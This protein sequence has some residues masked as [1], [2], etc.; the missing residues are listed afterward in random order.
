M[1]PSN[2]EAAL[3]KCRKERDVA[4]GH[5]LIGA[6][7][8]TK[9]TAEE[10]H[11]AARFYFFAGEYGRAQKA[12]LSAAPLYSDGIASVASDLSLVC[13]KLGKRE[14][15]AFF[16]MLSR[17]PRQHLRIIRE[18]V[19]DDET[20]S[21]VASA[22]KYLL[23]AADYQVL[24][25][26]DS[27][28]RR[29]FDQ[30][31]A[32]AAQAMAERS[33]PEAAMLLARAKLGLRKFG[34]AGAVV[35]AVLPRVKGDYLAHE[36]LSIASEHAG[37]HRS[38]LTH[39]EKAMSLN[40]ALRSAPG[41][42]AKLRLS[43]GDVK[44]AWEDIQVAKKR[45]PKLASIWALAGRIESCLGNHEA[46][47]ENFREEERLS[48]SYLSA[49][50]LARAHQRCGNEIEYLRYYNEGM[51]RSYSLTRKTW[52]ASRN[53]FVLLAPGGG[54]IL[55][56]YALPG[57]AL[58]V[59]DASATYYTLCAEHIAGR[60]LDLVEAE[61]FESVVF[62]GSS[63][64]A[65]ASLIIGAIVAKSDRCT[66]AVKALSFS[67]QVRLYPLNENL[68]IPSYRPLLRRA[69]ESEHIREALEKYG[70]A[71]ALCKSSPKLEAI[72]LYGRGYRMD[73]G[74]AALMNAPNVEKR[75][76]AFSG[77]GILMCYTIPKGLT[78]EAIAQKYAK[79][80]A[81]DEDMAALGAKE[82]PNLIEEMTALYFSGE[83]TLEQVLDEVLP[84]KTIPEV[85]E[86]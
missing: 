4:T 24:L 72:L 63:K 68:V 8:K 67:P 48:K 46:A 49:L 71:S 84:P 60:V 78:A 69:E 54:P 73:A 27:L 66:A 25:A 57:T 75:E 19:V 45:L 39:L 23:P 13:L 83:H 59:V 18:L 5:E 41:R 9:L 52:G 65:F 22:A 11:E 16:A 28:R 37:D 86:T 38:A 43:L 6:A 44:G 64:G 32:A 55:S 70:D 34:E 47:I 82:G 2:F 26:E 3:R 15:S 21:A 1:G 77:H 61:K 58:Y 29:D 17:D 20:S 42:A 50:N 10:W 51:E 40:P 81:G 30:A 33:S 7:D 62:I 35:E 79:L 14:A 76:I 36:I 31:E 74:E 80:K 12:L 85:M 53:L 56:K